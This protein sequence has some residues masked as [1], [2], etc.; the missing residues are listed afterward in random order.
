MLA[1]TAMPV[2]E[3]LRLLDEHVRDVMAEGK[4]P[5]YPQSM[6]AAW[7]LSVSAL[8]RQL[9]DG[10]RLLRLCAFFSPDSIPREVFRLGAKAAETPVAEVISD[11]I[12]FSR[13]IRELGRF[14]LVTLDG[15]S[16]TVHRLVQAL[17]RDELTAAERDSYQRE[18]HLIMAEAAPKNPDDRRSWPSFR[19][20]LPHVA[21][22]ST[23]LPKSREPAVRDLA[24][25]VMRYADQSGDYKSCIDLAERFIEQWTKDSGADNP[26]VL[27]AQRHLGNSLRSMGRFGDSAPLIEDTLNRARVVLGEKEPT[28]LSLR[29][30]SAAD[31]RANGDFAAAR[32]LDEQS[33]GL[34]DE[35][36]GSHDS[37][38]LRLLS[39]LALDH[40][41]NSQY[42]SARDLYKEASQYM[43]QAG[44]DSTDSDKLGA[45]IGLAWAL[46]LL[47][48]YKVALDVLQEAQ[49]YAEDPEGLA[50]EHLATLRSANAYTIVCRRIPEQRLEALEAGRRIFGVSNR[51]F[52]DNHPDT[53]AIAVSLSNLLRS[54]SAEHHPEAVALAESVVSRYPR[55][56]GKDHPYFYGCLGNLA[57]LRRET[58]DFAAARQLDEQAWDGL[59]KRL[60]ADHHYALTVAMNLASD[61]ARLGLPEQAREIGEQAL[62]L[63]RAVLGKDHPQTLGCA[64]NLALDLLASGDTEAGEKLQKETLE[65]YK[66]TLPSE[67]PDA[68]V[69]L[70]RGR[71][72]PDFDPP[73]I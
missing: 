22:E 69:A 44:S 14:A 61:L 55:A 13:A 43:N 2:D 19:D 46:R 27:R 73:P 37:R 32:G 39:S 34:F 6:T 18:V 11:P 45:W 56:Y 42:S 70:E 28:T 21:S 9:P 50:P 41:L 10:R 5:D 30:A 24:L 66:Q 8:E 62:P 23:A 68:V 35:V 25:R 58:G 52:G 15:R 16:V 49:D 57:L 51:L 59:K 40:G 60:G 20:L 63:L 54:I 4:S 33:R 3:Y 7:A 47:G 65:R 38:S 17:L 67:H 71:I 26:D 48:D 64:A 1:E 12:L 53:L 29:T 36:Y 31:L 72:D